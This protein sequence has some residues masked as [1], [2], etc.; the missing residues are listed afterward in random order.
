MG[1]LLRRDGAPPEEVTSLQQASMPIRALCLVG[2][3]RTS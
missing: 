1:D 3:P 2:Q